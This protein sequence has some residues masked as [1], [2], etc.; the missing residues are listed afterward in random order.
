MCDGFSTIVTRDGRILWIEP[1]EYGNIS[2]SDILHRAEIS[3]WDHRMDHP[4]DRIFVRS[5]IPDW[6]N[7]DSFHWDEMETLPIWLD[8]DE[9]K[10]KIIKLWLRVKEIYCNMELSLEEAVAR[11]SKLPG[12]LMGEPVYEEEFNYTATVN[13]SLDDMGKPPLYVDDGG[14]AAPIDQ[15]FLMNGQTILLKERAPNWFR[16]AEWTWH[17]SWLTDIRKTESKRAVIGYV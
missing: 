17:E 15:M 11:Y 14:C 13:L 12:F 10:E 6:D 8:Q 1:D 3:E 7:E 9:M 5:E 4:T 2:H 16:S